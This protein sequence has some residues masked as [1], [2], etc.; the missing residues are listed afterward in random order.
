MISNAG[1]LELVINH[2]SQ[3]GDID[4]DEIASTVEALAGSGDDDLV[5]DALDRFLEQE[6]FYGRD[7]IAGVMAA[8]MGQRRYRRCCW[9]PA[10]ICR[11]RRIVGRGPAALPPADPRTDSQ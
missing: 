5:H 1:L 6:N 11:D 9:P 8:V 2:A 4:Y 3:Q 10:A 7:L